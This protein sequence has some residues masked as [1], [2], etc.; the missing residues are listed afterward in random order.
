MSDGQVASTP[1]VAASDASSE[2]VSSEVQ[3]TETQAQAERRKLKAKVNG[4]ER[5]VYEDDVI[6]DYQKYASADEKLREAAQ[7]KKDIDAFYERLESDPESILNDP[8][9]PINKRDLAMKWLTEQIEEELTPQDPREAEFREMQKKLSEYQSK[10]Q[11]ENE[12]KAEQEKRQLVDQRREIIANTL[13]KAMELSPLSK[14]PE[15]AAQT[16]R[17]M[18]LHMRLCKDAGYDVSPEELASHVEKKN[19]KTYHT[20]ANRLE[21][22]DLI[23]FLGEDIVQKIRRADL[24]RIKK[25]RE[26]EA[27]QVARSWEARSPSQRSFVDPHELRS[28]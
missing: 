27:P 26:V 8:R 14:D 4:K 10:E 5:E 22:D 1:P 28:R 19:I 15:V 3:A 11:R 12:T 2:A 16:L 25:A 17:E 23:S 6:R 13:S 20:L 7:K 9:L 18:A 24:S 21:G